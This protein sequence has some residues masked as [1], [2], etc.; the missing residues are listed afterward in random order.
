[1]SCFRS[2][3]MVL[4]KKFLWLPLTHLS[5]KKRKLFFNSLYA[6]LH[7]ETNPKLFLFIIYVYLYENEN[8][9][10]TGDVTD[11]DSDPTIHLR[12]LDVVTLF[13]KWTVSC[14]FLNSPQQNKSIP[15]LH[16][17]M[18]DLWWVFMEWKSHKTPGQHSNMLLLLVFLELSI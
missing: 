13:I 18:T 4:V 5:N 6:T 3:T 12:W 17:V 10:Q 15:R 14:L 8:P 1:M 2:V 7:I 11:S 9:H 16:A